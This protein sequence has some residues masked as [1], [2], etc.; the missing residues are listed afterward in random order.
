MKVP[1]S[2]ILLFLLAYA[3]VSTAL[4]GYANGLSSGSP[5]SL[6]LRY[7]NDGPHAQTTLQPLYSKA[8]EVLESSNFNS[9]TTRWDQD[10]GSIIEG[11]RETVAGNYFVVSFK[12]P[13]KIKTI[14][15]QVAVREIVIGLNGQDYANA[16]YTIDD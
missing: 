10:L 8:L 1:K 14:G 7:G 12:E 11:F 15:G 5:Y 4:I 6:A 3:V 13:R 2:V 9:R 16:L